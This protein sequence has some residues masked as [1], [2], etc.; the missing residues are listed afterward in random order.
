VLSTVWI[1]LSYAVGAIVAVE[2]G[3]RSGVVPA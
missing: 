3:M 1:A 2:T